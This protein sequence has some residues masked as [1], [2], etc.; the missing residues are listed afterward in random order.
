MTQFGRLGTIS[1]IF[2]F[3]ICTSSYAKLIPAEDT[4]RPL[5]LKNNYYSA[6]AFDGAIF[7]TAT[8]QRPG[9]EN[10]MATLRFTLFVNIGVTFHCDFDK[11][12]GVFTGVD[13]KN[14]GFIEK[15]NNNDS[16]VKRRTY[17][18]GMPLG[19]KFGNMAHRQFLFAGGGLDMPFNFKE[20]GFISRDHKQKFNEWFSTRTPTFMPYIFFGLSTGKGISFK[21]QYYLGN[22]LSTDYK[23]TVNGVSTAPYAGYNVHLL[24]LSIGHSFHYHEYK[25]K[26]V[27]PEETKIAEL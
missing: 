16:T 8:M 15:T 3:A 24:L 22:F 14:I 6:G 26:I 2:F 20:K 25:N 5:F 12:W 9:Y 18:I 10:R 21:L 1:V 4:I 7:S 13:I 11:R 17:N 27:H 23:T 19:I